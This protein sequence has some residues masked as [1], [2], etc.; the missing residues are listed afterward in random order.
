MAII[1]HEQKWVFIHI[2]KT[3]GTSITNVIKG[4]KILD[5]HAH[6]SEVVK[7]IDDNWSDYFFFSFVRHPFDRLIS[8]YK[9][10]CMRRD[11]DWTFE[12]WY[13]Q[14]FKAP[15]GAEYNQTPPGQR[16]VP[17]VRK[18]QVWWLTD[19]IYGHWLVD[20]IGYFETLHDYLQVFSS[21]IVAHTNLPHHQKTPSQ[22]PR[23]HYMTERI[24]EQIYN[25]FIED[26]RAF[27]YEPVL[28]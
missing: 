6:A 28:S 11:L 23:S 1:N 25:D 8:F 4:R 15:L 24:A 17:N 13:W 20:R 3:A 12:Y 18:P 5:T 2:P 7:Y 21:S 16:V 14:R 9:F 26:F 22:N 27:N 19:E 10:Q